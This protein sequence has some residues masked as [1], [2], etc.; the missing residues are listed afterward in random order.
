LSAVPTTPPLV[1]PVPDY[2]RSE[3]V[4]PAPGDGPGY[5]AGGP[6]AALV[7]GTTWLAYRLRRPVGDG[8]GYAVAIARSLDGVAFD[9]VATLSR[10]DFGAASLERPALVRRPDGGWRIYISC[11]TPGSLHWWV[12]ALDADS[13]AGFDPA[14]RR[15]TLPGDERMA[16]K[17]PVVWHEGGRW[18]M[19]ACCHPLPDPAEADRMVSR[20]AVSDDGVEWRWTGAELRGGQGWD[21]RGARVACRIAGLDGAPDVLLY[22]GRATAD[23]NWEELT[24]VAVLPGEGDGRGDDSVAYLGMPG[25]PVAVSPHGAGGL[26][27]VSAVPL[28]DGGHRLYYEAARP[29]GAHD[30]RTELVPPT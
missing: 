5:W 30:L 18:H 10:D 16:V 24:G 25:G 22:D 26:R 12:D 9:H 8:R 28:P 20:R 14:T 23:Q 6:S 1:V 15:T 3:V 27:Y 11:S 4:V 2:E 19:W 7:D 21:D 17:D 29:D 13:P